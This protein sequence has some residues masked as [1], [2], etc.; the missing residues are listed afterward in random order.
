[1]KR[2]ILTLGLG[3]LALSC[4]KGDVLPGGIPWIKSY[5][6]GLAKAREQGKPKVSKVPTLVVIDPN[7][8]KLEGKKMPK[9]TKTALEKILKDLEKK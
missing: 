4:N 6:E 9:E 2:G 7:A 1:M 3:L 5:N 8:E